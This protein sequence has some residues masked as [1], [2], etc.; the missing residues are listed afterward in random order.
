MTKLSLVAVLALTACGNKKQAP[1]TPASTPG[2]A[3]PT[4]SA[5]AAP[6]GTAVG[7]CS[8]TVSGDVTL[9]VEGVAKTP[10][11]SAAMAATEYW[12]SERSVRAGLEAMEGLDRRKSKE[13]VAAAVDE[14]M[15]KDPRLMLL[16][17][18]CGADGG[19]V[20]LGASKDSKHADVAMKPG[21][22]VIASDAKA[23][24]FG[25]LFNMRAPGSFHISEPGTLEITKFD[26]TGIA[27]TFAFKAKSFDE[28]RA[29]EV[30]GT[31]DYP[32]VGDA[33]QK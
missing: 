26:L 18:N 10:P 22:Y 12:M 29:V 19:A 4:T 9:T 17:I 14:A 2:A 21:K 31:F 7:K 6:A 30:H 20:D 25:V 24:Q 8:F 27:G 28:K 23:G 1:P 32:C 5:A 13:Q 16:S 15:K 11:N 33:C 3:V